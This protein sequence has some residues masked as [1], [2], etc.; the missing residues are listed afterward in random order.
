MDRRYPLI[1]LLR[2]GSAMIVVIAHTIMLFQQLGYLANQNVLLN[3][4]S[5]SHEAVLVFFMLSGYLVGGSVWRSLQQNRFHFLTYM[6]LRLNRLWLPLIPAL[7]IT[8]VLDHV[9]VW[10]LDYHQLLKDLQPFYP[11][12]WELAWTTSWT[13]FVSNLFFSQMLLTEQYGTNLSLWTL[14]NEYWYYVLFPLIIMSVYQGDKRAAFSVIAIVILFV[15][16]G[17]WA[18]KPCCTLDRSM[19]Y[20]TGFIVWLIGVIAASWYPKSMWA[21]TIVLLISFLGAWLYANN[22]N[23]TLL[24]DVGF[25]LVSLILFL[26]VKQIQFSVHR[27]VIALSEMS[28]SIYLIH[29]PVILFCIALIK[30]STLMQEYLMQYPLL[31]LIALVVFVILISKLFYGLFESHYH[32][33]AQWL[34]GKL[35]R[36]ESREQ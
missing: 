23:L 22:N 16:A 7:I 6:L 12:W 30:K 27:W 25:A 24:G 3:I 1:D 35:A 21:Y 13:V 18:D 14:S 28:Y 26:H 8:A 17:I 11:N 10:Y 2:S 32:A 31:A 33:T 20:F 36:N 29:L 34:L 4:A 15:V 9:G 19:I 5:F